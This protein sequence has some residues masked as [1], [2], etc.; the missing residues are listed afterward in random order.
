MKPQ[1]LSLTK[2]EIKRLVKLGVEFGQREG[3][4]YD[5][6]FEEMIWKGELKNG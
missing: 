6:W 4:Y 2:R 3:W 1:K 5:D